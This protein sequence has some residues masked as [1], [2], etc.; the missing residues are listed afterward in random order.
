MITDEIYE[1]MFTYATEGV[2]VSNELG[3]IIMCNPKAQQMFGYD[4]ETFCKLKIEDLV[5]HRFQQKHH[6]HRGN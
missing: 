3:D 1:G 2:I 4:K 5:P 6:K